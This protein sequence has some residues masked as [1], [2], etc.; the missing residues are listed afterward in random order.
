VFPAAFTEGTGT[1]WLAAATIDGYGASS[2]LGTLTFALF[3]A[4]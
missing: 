3:L 1:D 4:A 2:T